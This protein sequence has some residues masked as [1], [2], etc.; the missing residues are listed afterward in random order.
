MGGILMNRIEFYFTDF[1]E[2][3]YGYFIIICALIGLIIGT[4]LGYWGG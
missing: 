1:M 4:I 2:N 3:H